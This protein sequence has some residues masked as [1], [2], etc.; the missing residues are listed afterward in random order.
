MQRLI[1]VGAGGFGREVFS[2]ASQHPDCGVVWEIAGFLD[3]DPNALDAYDYPVAVIDSITS[4][5]PDVDEVFV[6]AIGTPSIKRKV[7]EQLMVKSAQ[8]ITLVHPSVVLGTNVTLGQG[9]VLCPRVTLTADIVVEPFAL[10]NCHSSAGH[11]VR[12]GA[13]S[14]VSGHCDLTGGSEVSAG[15]F[16]GTGVRLLPGKSVGANAYVGAGSVVLRSVRP[17]S[18]VFGNPAQPMA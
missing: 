15:A 1:I 7:C 5:T 2:W 8:F 9:V 3:D 17:E 10:M 16:L 11:D 13:W 4:H 18:R 6:C 12:I 14:T